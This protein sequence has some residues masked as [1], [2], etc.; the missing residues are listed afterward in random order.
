MFRFNEITQRILNSK[1]KKM[2]Q[3]LEFI[4]LQ[5]SPVTVKEI[6]NNW[7]KIAG[8]RIIKTKREGNRVND[9][10]VRNLMNE[11]VELDLLRCEK[12]RGKVLYSLPDELNNLNTFLNLENDFSELIRWSN[13]FSKYKGLPFFEDLQ[14]LL[15]E[16]PNYEEI[17]NDWT[18]KRFKP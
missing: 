4:K 6:E 17:M 18:E 10:T 13:T 16:H 2:I 3:I 5:N 1:G 15:S 9:N 7:I 12:N 8:R 11:M 14:E